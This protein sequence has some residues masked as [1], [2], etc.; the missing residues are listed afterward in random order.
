MFFDHSHVVKQAGWWGGGGCECSDHSHLVKQAGGW[1][2]GWGCECSLI[3][4][5]L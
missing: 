2:G 3:T 4:L 1:G 5:T